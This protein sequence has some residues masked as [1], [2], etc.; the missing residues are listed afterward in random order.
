MGFIIIKVKEVVWFMFY[1]FFGS[2]FII[3]WIDLIFYWNEFCFFNLKISNYEVVKM[4]LY[5][6]FYF[7]WILSLIVLYNYDEGENLC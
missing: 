5:C 7:D 2:E 6:N 1:F 4:C 3:N